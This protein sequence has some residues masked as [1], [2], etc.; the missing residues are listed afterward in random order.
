MHQ[1]VRPIDPAGAVTFPD[2]DLLWYDARLLNL[3]GRGWS[4]GIEQPFDRLPLRAREPVG[5]DVWNLSRHS[6][7]MCVRFRS[8][9]ARIAARW[10]LLH[11]QLAMDHMPATGVS[12]LDLYTREGDRWRWCGISRGISAV[13]MRCELLSKAPAEREYAM[14]LPLYNGVTELQVGIEPDAQAAA[15]SPRT[16]S[17]KPIVFYGTSITQGGCASRPGMAYPAILGR[18]LDVETLNFGFSGNGPMQLAIAPFLAEINPSIFVIDSLPNMDPAMV[19]ER[20]EP[21]V[22]TL[23]DKHPDVPIVLIE[24]MPEQSTLRGETGLRFQRCN[25]Q[26]RLAYDRLIQAGDH[27]LHYICGDDLVGDDLEATVDGTHFTDLGYMR[28]AE[29]VFPR[30]KELL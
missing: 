18:W 13:Q 10:T 27:N 23:R 3:E 15:A 28:F 11:E 6:A 26:L 12:G 16:G 22:Q 17:D 25:E 21:F 9:S 29:A 8:N 2:D 19:T 5:A 30:L 14:Y 24:H 1:I 4:D 20:A 7:G